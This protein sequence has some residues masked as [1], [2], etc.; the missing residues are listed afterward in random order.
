MRPV[1]AHGGHRSFLVAVMPN[2]VALATSHRK[3]RKPCCIW[4]ITYR[5]MPPL[6]D[7]DRVA[8]PLVWSSRWRSKHK[9]NS[10]TSF[11]QSHLYRTLLN[12]QAGIGFAS[13]AVGVG[14]IAIPRR[15]LT[16]AAIRYSSL[17]RSKGCAYTHIATRTGSLDS[18]SPYTAMGIVCQHRHQ[19]G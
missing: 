11:C 15:F 16:V 7:L 10:C 4:P 17:A 13:G 14:H 18:H 3:K 2:A 19:P 9:L 5:A 1:W 12:L 8:D 6:S